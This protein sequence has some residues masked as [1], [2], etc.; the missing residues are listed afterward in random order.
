MLKFLLHFLIITNGLLGFVLSAGIT[1]TQY[2]T[3][4]VI[5]GS[6]QNI[7]WT[8]PSGV[9]LTTTRVDIYQNSQFLQ[10]LGM[11]TN[12]AK[13]FQWSVS[14]NA[15]TGNSYAIR[16][17]ATSTLGNTAWAT[18]P[19]F[20]IINEVSKNIASIV[21]IIIIILS[22]L[23]IMLACKYCC[24]YRRKASRL[25]QSRIDNNGNYYTMNNPP[26]AQT[27]HGATYPPVYPVNP[28]QVVTNGNR[29]YSGSNVI[30]A[31]FAGMVGGVVLDEA[32][33]DRHH[34]HHGDH[35]RH[36][37]GDYSNFGGGT[38]GDGGDFSDN[39]NNDI[40]GSF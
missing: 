9:I 22:G 11:A 21:N 1:I 23:C 4:N 25:S 14:K 38:F 33:S 36:N 3:N 17:T 32:L 8:V 40:G 7:A 18:S 5:K 27:V 29:G 24:K 37:S 15:R 12:N 20:N 30:G 2:P 35:G 39:G 31:A 16:V 26:V 34:G 19:L 10:N 28:T 13:S 6:I